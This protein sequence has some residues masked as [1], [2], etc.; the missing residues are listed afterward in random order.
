MS[1]RL[2]RAAPLLLALAVVLVY[3]PS[4]GAGWLD[5]DDD[6]LVRDN[7]FFERPTGAALAAI[8]S[9]LSRTTR[10]VLGAEYLPV[11][12]TSH[13]LEALV[14]GVS[15]GLARGVSL[16]IYV[17]AVL[18][19]RAWLLRAFAGARIEAEVA[20]WLF[21]LHPV[22]AESVAWIAGRKD[23]LALLF[24]AAALLAHRALDPRARRLA[25]PAL[26]FLACLSKSMS[27]VIPALLVA[28]D[29]LARRRS[30]PVEIL[31]AGIAAAATLAVH[32]VVGGE[33][34]ILA[35]L[36]GGSRAAAFTTMG[37]VVLRYLGLSFAVVPG[38]I[39]H[40]V[41]ERS[42]LDPVGL[43]AWALVGALAVAAGVLARRGD[44]TPAFALAW[45]GIALLPVSQL[46]APLQNRMADR[47][48]LLGVLGPCVLA[49]W[50][51]ARAAE[52]GVRPALV[53]GLAA[54]L[55]I[56]ASATALLR[57]QAFAQ[58]EVLWLD[59]AERAPT[60]PLGPYQLGMLYQGRGEPAAAEAAF[61]EALRRDAMRT[62]SGRRS[63]NNLAIL[64]ARSGRVDEA[65]TLLERAAERY[66]NDPRVRHNL[67]VLLETRD[68]ERAR[69]LREEV[70]RR[71]PDYRPDDPRAGPLRG[72]TR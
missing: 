60:R 64:L 13:W 8:W 50:A 3:A 63:A 59:A 14:A 70:R 69:A 54:C 38:S 52:R 11:R 40:E 19:V 44:R 24:V 35:T 62:E 39:V 72:R 21:A 56:G 5:Y 1:S 31:G 33:V 41:P 9:D 17:G 16:A 57:V 55:V 51:V 23:V 68:P 6:W 65:I 66:P 34:G 20:A 46:L 29:W 49:A 45:L 61:R 53:H 27:I 28:D 42:V 18:L 43:A 15:P 37:P 30:D 10:L 12:D 32:L 2:D 4:L 48:L 36:P 58:P 67:A 25:V 22:H 7:P 47:Y 71:F 26:T